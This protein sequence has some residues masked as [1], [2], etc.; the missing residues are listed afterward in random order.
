MP[1]NRRSVK[2][3]KKFS[4]RKL[5]PPT[6][7]SNRSMPTYLLAGVV[8]LELNCVCVC[9]RARARDVG[10]I[11]K[12]GGEAARE[13][14]EDCCSFLLRCWCRLATP[15]SVP[16][17]NGST[18]GNPQIP[19]HHQFAD[20]QAPLPAIGTDTCLFVGRWPRCANPFGTIPTMWCAQVREITETHF[21]TE[22]MRWQASAL[23]AL[24]ESCEAYL[25]HLFEDA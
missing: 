7:T 25:V 21:T 3:P 12:C 17:R 24:Q 23:E 2:S 10:M 5:K 16:A 19:A 20:A 8:S 11:S 18:E 13:R 6:G 4:V 14:L 22:P 9:V 1:V 15:A